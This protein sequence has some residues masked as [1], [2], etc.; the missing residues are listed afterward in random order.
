MGSRGSV[1]ETILNGSKNDPVYITHKDMTRFWLTLD[2]CF[3]LVLSSLKDM[4]GG[5]VFVPN[6]PSMKLTDLFEALAPKRKKIFIGVRPGEKIHETLITEEEALRAFNMKGYFLIIPSLYGTS[7]EHIRR[8][9]K[10]KTR[11][12]PL[13]KGFIYSS[14]T[15]KK[16]LNHDSLRSSIYKK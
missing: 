2:Q 10:Y 16:W 4:V 15:N 12:K 3:K 5:E 13:P 14:D 9:A 1:I 7:P 11:G 8:Y 6:A